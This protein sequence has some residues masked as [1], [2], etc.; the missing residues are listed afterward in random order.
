M[1]VFIDTRVHKYT[2]P[3][4]DKEIEIFC[5]SKLGFDCTIIYN[6]GDERRM[7]NCHEFHLGYR[8]GAVACESDVHGQ[9]C[10][11]EQSDI[12]SV[13]VNDATIMY[14]GAGRLHLA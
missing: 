1:Y 3:A 12:Q 7:F 6:N 9:G 8:K 10:G 5:D 11:L 14:D 13:T 2:G 4:G